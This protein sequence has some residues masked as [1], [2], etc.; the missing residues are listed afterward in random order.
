MP[1]APENLVVRA[2]VATAHTL[3]RAFSGRFH[4]DDV[5]ALLEK[6]TAS[7]SDEQFD[8]GNETAVLRGEEHDRFGDFVRIAQSPE[9]DPGHE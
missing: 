2:S 1:G 6:S 7:L 4:P 5:S 9:R 3:A 8:P